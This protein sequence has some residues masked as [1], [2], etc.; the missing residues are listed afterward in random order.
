M[1]G[2]EEQTSQNK[3]EAESDRN[4]FN[5]SQKQFEKAQLD[6]L[7]NRNASPGAAFEVDRNEF[8]DPLIQFEKS[9]IDSLQKRTSEVSASFE[10]PKKDFTEPQRQ[11]EGKPLRDHAVSQEPA[12]ATK[13]ALDIRE[14]LSQNELGRLAMEARERTWD[15]EN[16]AGALEERMSA[17][18]ISDQEKEILE[19]GKNFIEAQDQLAA[20]NAF[21]PEAFYRGEQDRIDAHYETVRRYEEVMMESAGKVVASGRDDILRGEDLERAVAL[22]EQTTSIEDRQ[23]SLIDGESTQTVNR[24]T[25]AEINSEKERS[26]KERERSDRT[27]RQR[28]DETR[29][30]FSYWAEQAR[31]DLNERYGSVNDRE[32]E[33]PTR[34]QEFSKEEI[35]RKRERQIDDQR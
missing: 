22:T 18:D 9:Q 17:A 32:R 10:L 34:N 1:E 3:L 33:V 13:F 35:E 4:E 21:N 2:S 15:A 27:E 11:T 24:E 31:V 29:S 7:L 25:Y 20:A 30:D 8:N 5:D 19:A 14:N 23:M 16:K 28:E 26:D 12:A 6:E